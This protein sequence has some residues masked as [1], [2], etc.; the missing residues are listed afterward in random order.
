MSTGDVMRGREGDEEE[1]EGTRGGRIL[2]LLWNMSTVDGMRGREGGE[3]EEEG[4][5]GGRSSSSSSAISSS[6]TSA[7][8]T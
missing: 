7:P 8:W 6:G 5:R 4:R 1:G 3:L 2:L